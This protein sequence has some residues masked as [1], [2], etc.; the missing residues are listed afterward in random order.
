MENVNEGK[1]RYLDASGKELT[2]AEYLKHTKKPG[3][4]APEKEEKGDASGKNAA[5]GKE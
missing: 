4:E 1:T 5:G 2:E 3:A